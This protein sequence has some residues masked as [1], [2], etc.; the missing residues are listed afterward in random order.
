[1]E[2]EYVGKMS[3]TKAWKKYGDKILTEDEL[4]EHWNEVKENADYFWTYLL[5]RKKE[6]MPLVRDRYYLFG[7]GRRF[8]GA[9]G[10]LDFAFGVV[11]WKKE[12]R[13]SKTKKYNG[14]EDGVHR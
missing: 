5:N 8:V 2:I 7:N 6:P 3:W 13:K 4:N 1:M 10:R 9:Y 12:A 14:Q 11:I